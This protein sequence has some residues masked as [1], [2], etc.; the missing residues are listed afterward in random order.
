[1]NF[2]SDTHALIRWFTNSPRISRRAYE[3]L[4]QCEDGKNVVFIPSIVVAES[5]SIFDKKRV[6]F[7]FKRLFG[8]IE[9][10]ENFVLIALDYPI[11]QKM[12]ELKNIPELHDK[13]FV[14]SMS[15]KDRREIRQI[16]YE[17]F[18]YIEEQWDEFQRRL[19]Q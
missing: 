16:I 19:Q 11:L 7:D 15:P 8:M 17:H 5:L 3:I 4:E 14:F 9:E 18:E 1:M 12:V 2:V 6:S 13:A 10:S